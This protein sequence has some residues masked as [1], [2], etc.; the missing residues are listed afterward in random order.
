M[1]VPLHWQ[2]DI[3]CLKSSVS[4]KQIL[5]VEASPDM[6]PASSVLLK[7]LHPTAET[8]L[9]PSPFIPCSQMAR[10]P[11]TGDRP[12]QRTTAGGRSAAPLQGLQDR[13]ADDAASFR[14]PHARRVRHQHVTWPAGMCQRSVMSTWKHSSAAIS[15]NEHRICC[16][17]GPVQR[18]D[19]SH[20]DTYHS[21]VLP[22]FSGLS[23][24]AR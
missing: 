9:R 7:G 17:Q 18:P 16:V 19:A 6:L 8:G 23:L 2:G 24:E 12:S 10:P 20:R 14:C 13:S 1:T 15:Q 5:Q 22:S 4:S 21:A 11:R 3:S